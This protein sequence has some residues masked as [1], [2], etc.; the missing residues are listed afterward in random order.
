MRRTVALQL[1]LATT[2][3]QGDSSASPWLPWDL[4]LQADSTSSAPSYQ[5]RQPASIISNQYPASC[6]GVKFAV[7]P[8]WDKGVGSSLH[9]AGEA[10]GVGRSG[11][12]LAS[13]PARPAD[14]LASP[15][16]QRSR[17]AALPCGIRRTYAGPRVAPSVPLIPRAGDA[18]SSRSRTARCHP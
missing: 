4:R 18:T 15:H 6:D 11:P 14:R 2:A 3:A 5:Y 1:L 9:M 17:W 16:T 8:N 12:H 13:L 10:L 7:L